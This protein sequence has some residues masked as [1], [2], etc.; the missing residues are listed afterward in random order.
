[1]PF[2]KMNKPLAKIFLG[3]LVIVLVLILMKYSYNNFKKYIKKE[4]EDKKMDEDKK[5]PEDISEISRMQTES[6]QI[7][8]RESFE[9]FFDDLG[10]TSKESLKDFSERLETSDVGVYRFNHKEVKKEAD[11]KSV[12]FG[13]NSVAKISPARKISAGEQ[14]CCRVMEKI[15]GKPFKSVWPTW[16]KNPETGRLLE[17]DCYNEELSLAVE[18]NGEQHYNHPNFTNNTFEEFQKQLRRDDFKR[19]MCDL[20]GVYLIPVPYTVAICDIEKY[21]IGLLPEE[22]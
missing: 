9:D 8:F 19:R 3:F 20:H 14:E 21:I 18:Y 5:E 13:K 15:Y 2:I 1:M 7:T 11:I 4:D 22:N 17:L 16:L 6:E 10:D 12:L